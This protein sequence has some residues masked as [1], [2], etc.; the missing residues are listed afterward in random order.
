[1]RPQKVQDIDIMNSLVKAFRSN[2]YEGTSL[3]ELSKST[4][5]KKA[6][7]Y[8]RFPGGKQEMASAVLNYIDEWVEQHI[9]KA[10]LDESTPPTERL[11]NGLE[12]IKKSYGNG[13]ETCIFRALSIGQGLELFDLQ[14][15]NGMNK[16][17]T[18]FKELGN[19]LGFSNEE[20]TKNAINTLIKIQGSLIV[21]KGIN[22]LTIFETT[23]NEIKST[24]LNN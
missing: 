7:L 4:G 12:E 21:T 8:H 11:V 23:L 1:M 13:N 20:A 14:I 19:S 16:W 5:L 6:S 3:S 22:D 15:K 24:F 9:F 17:I 2:G 18:V 10:F